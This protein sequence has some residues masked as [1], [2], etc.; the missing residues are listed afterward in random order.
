MGKEEIGMIEGMGIQI[1]RF[2]GKAIRAK[3]MEGSERITARSN[4]AEIAAWVKGAL[5][6]LD[7]LVAK[8]KR[9]QI[10]PNEFF[11]CLKYRRKSPDVSPGLVQ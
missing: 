5:E 6:R 9:I 1:E 7:K 2:A 10:S 3:V 11:S 8:E 4:P